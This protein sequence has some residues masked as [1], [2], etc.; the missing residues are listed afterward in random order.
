ML[1]SLI[2]S[3][4]I[5]NLVVVVAAACTELGWMYG[6][7][8]WHERHWRSDSFWVIASLILSLW[9]IVRLL[10]AAERGFL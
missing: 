8:Y 5:V 4:L 10:P 2:A 6:Q 7:K 3:I 1:G 9:L